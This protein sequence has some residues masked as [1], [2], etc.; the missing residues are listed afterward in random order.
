MKLNLRRAR[1]LETKINNKVKQLSNLELNTQTSV[2]VNA[3][4]QSEILPDLVAERTSFLSSLK[5]IQSLIDVRYNIRSRIGM[6]NEAFGVNGKML[7]LNKLRSEFEIYQSYIG[8]FE[9][10][11]Q[12]NLEDEQ[13]M[14]RSRLE[15]GER[16]ATSKFKASFLNDK[17]KDNF[18]S[19]AFDLLK[20]ID[21]IEDELLSL[22]YTN[23]VE[24]DEE[25]VKLLE[26]N[27]LL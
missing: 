21:E 5:N 7:E 22:N 19:K 8:E 24:L 12:K 16:F 17:D 18:K 1:K 23:F 20:K 26:T 6:A 4:L 9:V 10:V 15:N 27:N 13:S 14:Y 11:D 25:T 2:R 3:D